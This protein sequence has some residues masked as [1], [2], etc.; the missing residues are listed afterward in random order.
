MRKRARR[1]DIPDIWDSKGWRKGVAVLCAAYCL[2]AWV[3][4]VA[5]LVVF[6]EL[7]YL[8][9]RRFLDRLVLSA[10]GTG[11]L[12][13]AMVVSFPRRFLIY[14]ENTPWKTAVNVLQVV[15]GL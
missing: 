10:A 9:E 14:R 12:V 1:T 7:P 13:V 5:V 6:R 8:H 11:A 2:V 3:W 15:L 4:P